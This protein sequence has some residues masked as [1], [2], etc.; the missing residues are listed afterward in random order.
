MTGG[1]IDAMYV[2]VG[3]AGSIAPRL[4]VRDRIE[5]STN[6]N[7]FWDVDYGVANL[8]DVTLQ[9]LHAMAMDMVYSENAPDTDAGRIFNAVVSNK[10]ATASDY[11]NAIT[12]IQ[13]AV[14]AKYRRLN[15]E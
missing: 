11:M 12:E 10:N 4:V 3:F 5:D 15:L 1:H 6:P 9:E 13:N 2:T 8:V 14:R 7:Y